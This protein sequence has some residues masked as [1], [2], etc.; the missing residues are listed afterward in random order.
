MNIYRPV[1][2]IRNKTLIVN[3]PG[4]I[5][6]CIDCFAV[7]SPVIVHAVELIRDVDTDHRIH[8]SPSKCKENSLK[9]SKSMLNKILSESMENSLKSKVRLKFKCFKKLL[10]AP[11]H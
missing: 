2:G 6:A 5:Q 8:G 4:S 3:F 7:I 9:Q 1:C 11:I 10:I